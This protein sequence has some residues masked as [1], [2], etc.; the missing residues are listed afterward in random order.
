MWDCGFAMRWI[1]GIM[2]LFVVG[3]QN[4][5]V[6]SSFETLEAVSGK[7]EYRTS[8]LFQK[9]PVAVG[10]FFRWARV[11]VKETRVSRCART[12]KMICKMNQKGLKGALE[13]YELDHGKPF[14]IQSRSDLER[15]AQLGY[16]SSVPDD[17]GHEGSDHYR[18]DECGNVY[19]LEHGPAYE[20][21]Q[22]CES[23]GCEKALKSSRRKSLR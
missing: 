13:M 6:F 12:P 7:D 14:V 1:Y 3:I 4:H 21:C 22:P 9:F 2:L 17:P 20:E 11:P 19:C 16:L 5:G 8:K 10:N 15:L 18:S 23:G